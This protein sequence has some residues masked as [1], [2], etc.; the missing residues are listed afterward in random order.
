VAGFSYRRSK[1][2]D[3]LSN[4]KHIKIYFSNQPTFEMQSMV[5]LLAT[6]QLIFVSSFFK[7]KNFRYILIKNLYNNLWLPKNEILNL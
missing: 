7:W 6:I 2:K 5:M 3:V 4:E 1:T